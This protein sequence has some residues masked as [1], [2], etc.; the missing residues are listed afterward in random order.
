[1]HIVL[2]TIIILVASVTLA[3]AVVLYG[4]N[5]FQG[6]I[7][8]ESFTVFSTKLWVHS[9]DDNGLVWG[10]FSARN[11]G[12]K[13]VSINKISIHDKTFLSH[14]GILTHQ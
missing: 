6:A 2:T 5:L 3:S 8:Q 13:T 10:A 9:S 4:T 12:D 14:N 7:Q 1:M 11:G